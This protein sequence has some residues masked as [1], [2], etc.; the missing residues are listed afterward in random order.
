MTKP[1]ATKVPGQMGPFFLITDTHCLEALKAI[2]EKDGAQNLV[3]EL[4]RL[5]KRR[6]ITDVAA[7]LFDVRSCGMTYGPA[8]IVHGLKDAVECGQAENYTCHFA[9]TAI[10]YAMALEKLDPDFF[11]EK[12][13]VGAEGSEEY[14]ARRQEIMAYVRKKQP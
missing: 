8:G 5:M 11:R 9:M 1:E 7:E 12:K 14:E 10:V 6:K 2:L 13:H 4:H 3:G